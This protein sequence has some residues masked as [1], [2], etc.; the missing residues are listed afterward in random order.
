L[1]RTDGDR[2]GH[3]NNAVSWAAVEEVA[4]GRLGGRL[5]AE[6]E[7]RQPLDVTEEAAIVVAGD[8]VWLL[9]SGG[10][11]SAARLDPEGA[12]EPE[13]LPVR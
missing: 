6:L 11:R 3:V 7:Y 8:G 2:L 10:V 1:R 5:H 12:R 9:A 4:A 13:Q